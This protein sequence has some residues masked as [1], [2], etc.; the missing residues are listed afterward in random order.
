MSDNPLRTIMAPRSIAIVG[1]SNNPTKMGTIQYLNLLHS[2]FPGPVYPIHPKENQIF[3]VKA[4]SRIEDLPEVPDLAML[5]VPGHLVVDM[6]E[7]FGALGTRHAVIITAGFKE[8]GQDGVA[9]EAALIQAARANGLRFLGPN[10][11]GLVNTHLPLNVTAAPLISPPGALSLVSQSGTYITQT[12]QYLHERGVHLNKAVSV[13][14]EASIDVVDVLEFLADDPET[15]AIGMYIECI[16]RPGD[17]L[18]AARRI[19]RHV[20]IIAQYVGGTAAGARSGSSHTGA[21]AGPDDIYDGL[22]KQAGIIRANTIED[23]YRIG[24]AL[25]SQPLPAGKRVAILTNS[26]GPGTAMADTLDRMGMAVPAFSTALQEKLQ[27]LLPGHASTANP[28]DLTFHVDM[29]LMAQT[30]PE[31]LLSSDEVDALLIHGI[32]DTGWADLAYPVFKDIFKIS[33]EDFRKSLNANVEDLLDMPSR[34]KKPVIVSSFFGRADEAARRFQDGGIPVFDSPEKAA[35]A[36]ATLNTY[37]AVRS[38]AVESEMTHCPPP[39]TAQAII[40]RSNHRHW[41]EFEAKE[42]LRAYGVPTCREII[43]ETVDAAIQAAHTIGYPVAVKGCHANLAHKTERGLVHLDLASETAVTEACESIK[44]E[45]GEAAFLVCEMVYGKRE[46]IAGVHRH[47]GFPPCVL[48]GLGGIFAE[49]LQ[50]KTIRLAPQTSSE[51]LAQVAD[52]RSQALLD[53]H[54]GLAA[55]DRNALADILVKIGQLALDFP[56]IE[57]IDLNPILIQDGQPVVVDALFEQKK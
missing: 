43:A 13:G 15:R 10:C 50:D 22:F 41:N 48:F 19:T 8:T 40:A 52:I 20:P 26:G 56:Q 34:F 2:G 51:A 28:V 17:F 24:Q 6:I 3:G 44:K 33:R 9:R 25:S 39:K 11:M 42:M 45:A 32:M 36:M 55:V 16:R 21:L 47:P 49:V 53:A 57:A 12:L 54:R 27:A 14:N 4:Y 7:R 46:F 1:A 31:A 37:R 29:T 38:R 30:L 18:A 23:V 35:A 5:V